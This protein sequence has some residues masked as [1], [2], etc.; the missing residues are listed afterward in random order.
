VRNSLF[1][2]GVLSRYQRKIMQGVGGDNVDN[3]VR[4]RAFAC[5]DAKTSLSEPALS[6]PRA[7]F[8]CRRVS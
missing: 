6:C 8:L 1:D 5:L 3:Q 7:V 2:G 4:L